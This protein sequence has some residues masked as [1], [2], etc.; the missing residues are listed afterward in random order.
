MSNIIAGYRKMTGLTQKQ[1][2]KELNITEGTYRNKEKGYSSFKD[3]EMKVFYELVKKKNRYV[4][5]QEIFF[6]EQPTKKDVL[7]RG[8]AVC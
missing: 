2:A 1:M 5:F 6:T 8:E 7:E 4:T 3:E